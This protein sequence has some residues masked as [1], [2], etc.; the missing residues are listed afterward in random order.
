M[1]GLYSSTPYESF[2]QDLDAAIEWICTFGISQERTRIGEYK[3]AISVLSEIYKTEDL[4][5]TRKE[6]VRIAT[7]LY[8]A[9]DLISIHKGLAGKYDSEIGEHIKKY[10]KGPANFREEVV[11]ASS[12]LARNI[13]FELLVASKIVSANIPLDFSIKTD[14]ATKFDGRNILF[15]C[16]RPQSEESI[17][18]NIKDAF[19]QLER[20]YKNPIRAR[21]R[22]I[23]A[24][25]ISKLLNPEFML[26]IQPDAASLDRG[27]VQIADQF[28]LKNERLWQLRRNS[29]T[30]AVLIRFGI[31]GINQE[32]DGMLTYCQQ[33]CLTPLNAAGNRNIET[34]ERLAEAMS[35]LL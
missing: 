19:K 13:A 11:S 20:M 2:A 7:A 1:A 16:K 15:E 9:N 31:M 34:A 3:R 27:L 18:K 25:D 35:G 32:K 21:H 22:G 17:E 23:I 12:N 4:E 10:A 30:I 33:Y 28:I 6:F 26:Y 8:E 24:L 29:K 14:I 5:K